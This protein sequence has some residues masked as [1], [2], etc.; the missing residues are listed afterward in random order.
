M[1]PRGA[2]AAPSTAGCC[3][4]PSIEPAS[5]S[6]AGTSNNGDCSHHLLCPGEVTQPAGRRSDRLEERGAFLRHIRRRSSGAARTEAVDAMR[7]EE[8]GVE[9]DRRPGGQARSVPRCSS[10]RSS[11]T[12]KRSSAW[13]KSAVAVSDAPCARKSYRTTVWRS[14]S[15][16]A[17]AVHIRRSRLEPVIR[18]TA[19]PGPWTSYAIPSSASRAQR[20]RAC[21]SAIT[22]AAMARVIVFSSVSVNGLSGAR[23]EARDRDD[24][25][26]SGG[27]LEHIGAAAALFSSGRD[28]DQSAARALAAA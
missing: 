12:A 3:R 6:S 27:Q 28:H 22:A 18:T 5:A 15:Q 13:V 16:A 2:R 8:R 9:R 19:G 26:P 17:S 25:Q 7:S 14:R 4:S 10:R 24:P 21:A 11:S 20:L 23:P 1:A